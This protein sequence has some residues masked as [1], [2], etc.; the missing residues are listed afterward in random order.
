MRYLLPLL[1]LPLSLD[2]A[3]QYG[4]F[5]A[6]KVKNAKAHTTIV[7]LDD[8][9]TPYNRGI[10]NAVK[11]DWKFSGSYDFLKVG[12]LAMQPITPDKT[13]LVKTVKTDPT[14]Y[15]GTFLTLV[16]GWKLKK[17]ENLENRDNAF[18]NIPA[19]QELAFIMIDP[20]V[21]NE[22]DL[23]ALNTV[24]VKHL[25]DYLAQVAAG[26]ITDK[27]TADRIYQGRNRLIRDRE[28]WMGKEHLDQTMQDEAKVRRYTRVQ[29]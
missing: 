27:T 21:M 1:A 25:Q 22:K 20:K 15:E 26:K 18:S 2:L 7:V 10:M 16:Q 11:A 6:S 23:G 19:E 29:W 17:N 24:Y 5:D 13:Y 3:A 28:L 9:D 12:D 14:K 4:S 8:G